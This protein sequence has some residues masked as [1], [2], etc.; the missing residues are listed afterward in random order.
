MSTCLV[1]GANGYVGGAIAA[2]LRAEGWSVVPLSRHPGPDG[3][4]FHLGSAPDVRRLAGADCLVHCAYDFTARDAGTTRARN[5]EGTRLLLAAA[6]DAGVR[7]VLVV[8]SMSAFPGCR[9]LYG[10]TKMEMEALARDQGADVVRPGLVTGP[11][12]GG[13]FGALWKVARSARIIPLIDHGSHVQY[14]VH[15]DDL[16]RVVSAWAG[17]RLVWPDQPVIVAHPDPLTMK[18]LISVLA[19]LAGRNPRF[20]SLPGALVLA[21]LRIAESCGV[22]LKFRS[23]SLVGLMHP[24]PCPDFSAQSAMGLSLRPFPEG[25]EP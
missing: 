10:R 22:P 14:L 18:S 19:G 2:G 17:Q 23:D 25:L 24:N 15:Q 4:P 12:A 16:A 8:S 1:T 7:R 20:V 11:A 21:G 6:R 3:I 13:V 5:V 9:S